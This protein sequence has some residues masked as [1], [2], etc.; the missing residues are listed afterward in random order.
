MIIT[1]KQ[2]QYIKN[3]P[4]SLYNSLKVEFL[5]HSNH[6]EG[7]TFSKANLQRLIDK[8]I[9][10]GNHQL[11]DV[12]ETKNSVELYDRVVDT[13]EEL[14]KFLILDWHRKLKKGTTDDELGLSGGW[15]KY[16]NEI[17]GIDLHLAS[18][19]E[20]DSF[21]TNLIYD[22]NSK[23]NHDLIDIARFHAQF[24]KIHPFQDGNGRIG[25][26]IIL[27]Q[28]IDHGV[29]LIAIDEE[30]DKEY[31][32]ALYLAQK[33]DDLQ[34][35]VDCFKKC[36]ERLDQKLNRYQEMLKQIDED[37]SKTENCVNA[38]IRVR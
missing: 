2:F 19:L 6:I 20:V 26:Y 14:N 8:M 11:N 34:P 37:L 16:E 32:S 36:Q 33:N 18:P 35:L 4:N 15:K 25:R 21:V 10:E 3:I 24:E 27:K 22:W 12:L 30:Y 28:C 38:R 13:E 9:V 29:D 7:S 23:Q 31:R 17:S 5:F 1:K